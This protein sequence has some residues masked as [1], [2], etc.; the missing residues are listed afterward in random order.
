MAKFLKLGWATEQ[1][2]A[3]PMDDFFEAAIT[4]A[5]RK[6]LEEQQS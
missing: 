4:E 1:R 6:A 5:G 3:K 2:A